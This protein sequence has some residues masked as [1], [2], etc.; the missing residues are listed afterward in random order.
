MELEGAKGLSVFALS[1]LPS[2]T[3][4]RVR[5]ATSSDSDLNLFLTIIES[6]IP[7]YCHDPNFE[8]ITSFVNIYIL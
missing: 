3:W 8:S 6:G 4:D 5:L 7:K 2:T 1:S